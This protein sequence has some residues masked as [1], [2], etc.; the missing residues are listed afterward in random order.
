M[1]DAR[2]G[3]KWER[4][5]AQ[6]PVGATVWAGTSC[7]DCQ[8]KVSY[9]V[10][11]ARWWVLRMLGERPKR[12]PPLLAAGDRRA[13]LERVGAGQRA[14]GLRGVSAVGLAGGSAESWPW[15]PA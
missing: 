2:R 14:G 5:Q 1:M 4:G 6:V 13:F 10:P 3:G 12:S 8:E 7:R 11:H 15:P 9:T